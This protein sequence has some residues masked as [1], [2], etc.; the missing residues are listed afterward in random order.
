MQDQWLTVEAYTYWLG[1][2]AQ[3]E[4]KGGCDAHSSLVANETQES[5]NWKGSII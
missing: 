1:M 4:K 2:T 5:R 3:N